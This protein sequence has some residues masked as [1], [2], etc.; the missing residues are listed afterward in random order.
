MTDSKFLFAV[1]TNNRYTT[2]KR[3]MTDI[4]AVREAYN[5]RIISNNGLICSDDNAADAMKN[6]RKYGT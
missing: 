2:E 1:I 5:N 4:A 6:R 3:L